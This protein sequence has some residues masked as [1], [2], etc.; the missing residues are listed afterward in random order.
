MIV[1]NQNTNDLPDL[2]FQPSHLNHD[3]DLQIS[4]VQSLFDFPRL[5]AVFLVSRMI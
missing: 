2:G 3:F 5:A 4:L 1:Y